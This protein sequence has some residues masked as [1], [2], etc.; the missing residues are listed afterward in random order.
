MRPTLVPFAGFPGDGNRSYTEFYIGLS[1]DRPF[2]FHH[3]NDTTLLGLGLK[4]SS[5]I[6]GPQ[7]LWCS[8]LRIF[9]VLC[10]NQGQLGFTCV[11][12]WGGSQL[13]DVLLSPSHA[14]QG[15]EACVESRISIFGGPKV[16]FRVCRVRFCGVPV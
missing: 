8:A 2:R 11:M 15:G 7:L 14:F 1:E 6:L 4:L 9:G 5:L 13:R 12:L 3:F 10:R 16:R